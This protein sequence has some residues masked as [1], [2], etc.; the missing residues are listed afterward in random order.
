MKE[1][2]EEKFGSRE[3]LSISY[4]QR[5]DGLNR[6]ITWDDSH[7]CLITARLPQYLSLS[8]KKKPLNRTKATSFWLFFSWCIFFECLQGR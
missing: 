6:Q 4:R 5:E 8:H 2:T 1:V 7:L 3:W